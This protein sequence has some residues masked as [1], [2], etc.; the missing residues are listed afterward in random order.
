MRHPSDS[1][2]WKLVDHKWPDFASEPRNLRLAISADGI[3]PHSSMS[4]RHSCWPIIM[5]IY[6]L[7][8]WLCMKRKFMMLSLLISGPRQ[9]GNDIDVYLA[10]L[11]DDLKMLWD[12]G[13]EC[14]DVH[15]QEVFTL[16]VVLLWTINDFP[17]YGNLSGCVVKG[18]FA[19]PICGED[20]FS[21]RLKHGK[22]NSYTVRLCGPVYLRWMYP[23]E[24]FMK[25]LKGYVQNLAIGNNE[26]I[27]ET[28][29]WIAHGPSHYVSKY[30]GY[31]IN[32]CR[33]HTKERDDLRATQNS[34]VSIVASTMQIAS[35]KDQNLVFAFDVMD[36]SDATCHGMGCNSHKIDQPELLKRPPIQ[37][38]FIEDEN[39]TIFVKDRLST[40]LSVSGS[41]DILVE[42][43]GTPEYSGRV[44]AKGKHYT[45]RQYFNS[46][47]DR[48]VR[49]FIAA[50][51]EEQRIFQAEVLAKLTQVGVVTP[52]SDVS[53]S[54][55]TKT[56]PINFPDDVFGESFK[57]FMMK[58]DM[59]MI[60]SSKEVHLHRKLIDAKQAKRYVFVNP[61]LVS[62]AGIG[63]G[64]KENRSRMKKM[65]AYYLDPMA[66]QP[67]DDLKDIVNMAMRINPPEKQ[68]TS[69]GANLGESGCKQPG[70]VECGYYVMRYMKEII[71]NPNQLTSKLAVFSIW[72]ILGVALL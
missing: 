1:P 7:P 6:N 30:H 52:Q 70:S 12:V 54:K 28:L 34:G 17:A 23:F 68:K 42:A 3:N 59:E 43:L 35:A 50:S 66:H 45:P 61:A 57:T 37:Y 46:A 11:L 24:R 71:A 10:P 16:R 2:S 19:C 63:E 22:K 49:D 25:V 36:D 40:T 62:K 18:Y 21:H 44:R 51:K 55:E 69:K 56:Y 4:S 48:A 31:V 29:K 26:L 9:P 65:I 38:T 67:C 15:Q 33:Y 20:T 13:V 5:V 27:Y 64:N 53:K 72:I 8:P 58:E 60:I 41:N 14:Y 32:G 47:A 39:W